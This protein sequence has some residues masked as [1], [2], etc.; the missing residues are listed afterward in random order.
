MNTDEVWDYLSERWRYGGL[1]HW[2]DFTQDCALNEGEEVSRMMSYFSDFAVYYAHHQCPDHMEPA[3]YQ[4]AVELL[5]RDWYETIYVPY[6]VQE[7]EEQ[8]AVAG[9][10]AQ[11][12]DW[13]PQQDPQGGAASAWAEP[14]AQEHVYEEQTLTW[15]F[16]EET[17]EEITRAERAAELFDAFAQ[18]GTDLPH[19]VAEILEK[20]AKLWAEEIDDDDTLPTLA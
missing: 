7:Q 10:D 4:V 14:Q 6:T 9:Y 11:A 13:S 15:D 17:S 19:D 2:W 18:E 20:G 3:D 8:A 1:K 16:K 12:A 5:F